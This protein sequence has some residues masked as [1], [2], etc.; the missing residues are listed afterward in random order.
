MLNTIF[1]DNWDP[2]S[3]VAIDEWLAFFKGK[4]AYKV[5]IPSKPAK[6]GFKFFVFGSTGL[7]VG[8]SPPVF[9]VYF[10]CDRISI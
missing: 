3:E 10:F 2:S 9:F 8:F 5:Y 7:N 1:R 6:F 4:Y